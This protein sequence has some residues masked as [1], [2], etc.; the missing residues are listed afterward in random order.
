[1]IFYDCSTAP[2]PRRARMFIAEKGLNFETHDISIARSEQLS[3]AFRV[4]NPDATLPVLVTDTGL[5]LTENTAISTYIEARWPKPPLMGVTPEEKALVAMWHAI[6]EQKGA[7]PIGEAFRNSSPAMKDRALPGPRNFEQI[8]ALADR[9]MA[10]VADFF[11]LLEA[12]LTDSP[13]LAGDRFSLADI[14]GF[15]FVDFAR[16]IR[17]RIPEGNTATRRWFDGISSRPSAGA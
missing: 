6:C 8:P 17:T 14:T 1:M 15:V 5:T 2:N 3:D 9:A 13:Y 16:V 11:A 12:R 7:V 10:R 4:I